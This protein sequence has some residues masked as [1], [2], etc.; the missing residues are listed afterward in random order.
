MGHTQR[1]S[2]DQVAGIGTDGWRA[3]GALVLAALFWSGNFVAGRVLGGQIEPVLL[4]TLRWVICLVL[5]LPFVLG[6]LRANWRVVMREWRLVAGLGVTGIA[7]FHTLVYTALIDTTAI[8]A[9]L[10]LSLAPAAILAGAAITGMSRPRP[11]QWL[12]STVSLAG[13]GILITRANPALLA[14][15]R[16]NE[17]DLWMLGAV[18]VWAAYSL[19]LRQR[20]E[21]L[22][23]DAAL[24]ASVMVAIALLI[25]AT[26]VMTS[27]LDLDLSPLDWAVVLYI[28][29]CASLIAF[30]FWS[31]GVGEI[32]PERAGQFIHLMPVFGAGLAVLLLDETIAPSQAVGAAFVFSGIYLVNRRPRRLD[33]T[34]AG[35][36]H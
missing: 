20:P 7:A 4:N 26:L 13:A 12:G 30:L 24:G 27:G 33:R 5:F 34:S 23:Q 35:T 36:A 8:N 21:D 28:A 29:V 19:L 15:L 11:V 25:P 6:P 22:P 32:G 16:L 10:T 9:L 18:A 31:H 14:D 17:G 2:P 3:Y 1:T